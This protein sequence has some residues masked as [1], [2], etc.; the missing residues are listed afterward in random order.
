M[1]CPACREKIAIEKYANL[2]VKE[3]NGEPLYSQSIDHYFFGDDLKEYLAENDLK[4]EDLRLVFCEPEH[5]PQIQVEDWNLH[6]DYTLAPEVEAAVKALN[7]LL[8]KQP[9]HCWY[10]GKVAAKVNL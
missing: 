2:P 1:I 9:P 8:T 4:L 10:P 3:W 7:E 5:L 6:E